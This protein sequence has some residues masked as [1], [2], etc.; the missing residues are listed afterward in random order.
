MTFFQSRNTK[1]LLDECREFI[2]GL[3]SLFLFSLLITF[4]SLTPALLTLQFYDR[5]M[6]SRNTTTLFVLCLIGVFLLVIWT[7]LEEVRMTVLRRMAFRLDEK[8]SSR[9]FDTLNRF[10]E[11][12]PAQQSHLLIQDLGNVREF[13]GGM[14]LIHVLDTLCVPILIVAAALLHPLLGLLAIVLTAV[15]V[16]LSLL[17]QQAAREDAIQQAAANNNAAEFGR[18]VLSNGEAL[19]V[20]GMLPRLVSRWRNHQVDAIGWNQLAVD[21]ARTFTFPLR[22][23]RH[24]TLVIIKV[25]AVILFLYDQ[26]GVG[27]VFASVLIIIRVIGPVDSL[28]NGWRSMWSASLSVERIGI[29]LNKA[30]QQPTPIPLQRPDGAL[31]VSRIAVAPRGQDAVT[32][33]D[34]SF[35]ALPGTV[36]GVVGPSGAGK[37]TLA[38]ALVGAWPLVRGSIQLDG[39]ELSHWNQDELGR[40]IGYVP[41]EIDMLP[42]TLAENIARFEPLNHDNSTRLIEAV[43]LAGI[44]D[45]VSKLPDGLSTVMGPEGRVLSSGQRQ[46][47]ALARAAY[48][49]PRL[50][51][52]D[53]PNSNI[54]STGEQC[55]AA[56]ISRLREAGAIVVLVT[57]RMNMLTY[58]DQ[59]LVMNA[60]TVHTYGPREQ[61]LDRITTYRPQQQITDN[62]PPGDARNRA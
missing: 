33:Q 26:I 53:E 6:T 43:K 9:V 39:N 50:V 49:D 36:I 30:M 7:V 48:G 29:V 11:L 20:M 46:R 40:H 38:R 16:A 25:V 8:I 47:V 61:I 37:S 5:V 13:I 52:L 19:R 45:I 31:V 54:D 10:P 28:A 3:R 41:Q 1:V 42:G 17:A 35:T 21:R 4:L 59:V 55:L 22:L 58:C 51:V 14:M 56:A 34:V 12:V 60:G 23:L 57:H 24:S 27:A 18:T 44:Q 62:R 32:L 15:S 2:P